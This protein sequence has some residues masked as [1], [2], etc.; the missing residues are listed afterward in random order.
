MVS[1]GAHKLACILRDSENV[2]YKKEHDG[3]L[4]FEFWDEVSK[5]FQVSMVERCVYSWDLRSVV[6]DLI[7][8]DESWQWNIDLPIHRFYLVPVG[9]SSYCL[10]HSGT[11]LKGVGR[12][13]ALYPEDIEEL[14]M[15]Q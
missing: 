13:E 2:F 9:S 8:L 7:I 10:N 6:R 14:R 4:G 15:N 1:H 3:S 5:G 11:S 12:A